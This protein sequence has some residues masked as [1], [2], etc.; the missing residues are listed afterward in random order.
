M[1]FVYSSKGTHGPARTVRQDEAMPEDY[2]ARGLECLLCKNYE[3]A[4]KWFHLA[5]ERGLARSQLNLGNRYA[6]GQGV[7]QDYVEAAK[8]IRL[9]AD[10]GHPIAQLN[11]GKI[12]FY[13]GCG[14]Q[15]DHKK[16]WELLQTSAES[17]FADAQYCLGR[18]YADPEP[19]AWERDDV[20]AYMWLILASRQGH[21][22]ADAFRQQI[23]AKLTAKQISEAFR[24]CGSLEAA[25]YSGLLS[26]EIGS[27][28]LCLP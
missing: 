1:L 24:S 26:Q 10:Q 27:V 11:L 3:T 7:K 12:V 28:T 13:Q 16:A 21:A 14:V 20:R 8:W 15:Q 9:A 6:L 18:N 23:G 2:D 4:A 17:G 19:G 5:A 22:E 25:S